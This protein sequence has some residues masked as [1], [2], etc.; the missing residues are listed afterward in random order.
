[1]VQ[2]PGANWQTAN[3]RC[4]WI[5]FSRVTF[6]SCKINFRCE[7]ELAPSIMVSFFCSSTKAAGKWR[8]NLR[9]CEIDVLEDATFAAPSAEDNVEE[10]VSLG[11][12][13]FAGFDGDNATGLAAVLCGAGNQKTLSFASNGGPCVIRL[14]VCS[15]D[16]SRSIKVGALTRNRM[17]SE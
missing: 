15:F 1:M 5:L 14:F 4:L 9:T 12:S 6:K 3:Q 7:S 10:A 8:S 16:I 2:R 11:M 17:C 13:T